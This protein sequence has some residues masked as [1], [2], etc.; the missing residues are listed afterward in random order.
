[1]S[2][3]RRWPSVDHPS[4]WRG[5][6]LLQAI[7]GLGPSDSCWDSWTTR[8]RMLC[9]H[10]LPPRRSRARALERLARLQEGGRR[11]VPGQTSRGALRPQHPR[12]CC[13]H[14]ASQQPILPCSASWLTSSWKPPP[15]GVRIAG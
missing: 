12:P 5:V 8:G 10:P 9:C 11:S 13:P 1:M 3:G 7:Y 4:S 2:V 15:V 14:G 6:L